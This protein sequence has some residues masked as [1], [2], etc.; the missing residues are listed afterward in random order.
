MPK[1]SPDLIHAE[2]TAG[3]N[4]IGLFHVPLII[5]ADVQEVHGL[6]GSE[7]WVV[8]FLGQ[9][10]NG[11]KISS[12]QQSWSELPPEAFL[13]L[14]ALLV[15][16]DSR[17]HRFRKRIFLRSENLLCAEYLFFLCFATTSSSLRTFPI[18]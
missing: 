18:R 8:F 16:N 7:G 17:F 9:I 14:P 4:V 6:S 13:T 1:A 3:E 2:N 10:C 5:I 12:H 11:L 15:V